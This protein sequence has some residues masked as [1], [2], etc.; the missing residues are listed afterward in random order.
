MCDEAIKFVSEE[1]CQLLAR[2]LV[3]IRAADATIQIK[4]L[5][6]EMIGELEANEIQIACEIKDFKLINLV[7]EGVKD[8]ELSRIALAQLFKIVTTIKA[9]SS[10]VSQK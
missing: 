1:G 6:V 8:P 9:G 5:V 10:K 4:K 3:K 7:F 2:D